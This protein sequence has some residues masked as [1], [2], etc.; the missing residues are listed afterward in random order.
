M[1]QI[2]DYWTD[3]QPGADMPLGGSIRST[4]DANHV[5]GARP[6]HRAQIRPGPRRA[7]ARAGSGR[8]G[9]DEDHTDHS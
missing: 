7:P 8:P 5:T 3:P 4:S 2:C 1:H 9:C 6:S